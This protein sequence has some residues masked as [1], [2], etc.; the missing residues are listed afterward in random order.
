M[1]KRFTK[2]RGK[3]RHL[4]K[5]YKKRQKGGLVSSNEVL[6]KI[7]SIGYEFETD[8]LVPLSKKQ[9]T[10][11]TVYSEFDKKS[12]YD[13]LIQKYPLIDKTFF[14][15]L[16]LNTEIKKN[17]ITEENVYSL[18]V[19][20]DVTQNPFY[21]QYEN[22]LAIN[23]KL[24][25]N[26]L[27]D[28]DGILN[29]LPIYNAGD[30]EFASTY[31]NLTKFSDRNNIINVT[32]Q[33]SI[34]NIYNFLTNP[35]SVET[36]QITDANTIKRSTQ[37]SNELK[38]PKKM[39]NYD[40]L[41]LSLLQIF[42]TNI[43][44]QNIEYVRITPQMTFKS[45]LK[46]SLQIVN[47]LL[48]NNFMETNE[49]N[50]PINIEL[51]NL[52]IRFMKEST[53]YG[54]KLADKLSTLFAKYTKIHC[55]EPIIID[56]DK[57]AIV[58]TYLYYINFCVLAFEEKFTPLNRQ[59]NIS[60]ETYETIKYYKDLMLVK[61]RFNPYNLFRLNFTTEDKDENED[62]FVIEFVRFVYLICSKKFDSIQSL[63]TSNKT[64]VDEIQ[65][66]LNIHFNDDATD[67][68]PIAKI[69]IN[70]TFY[71]HPDKYLVSKSFPTEIDQIMI[72]YRGFSMALNKLLQEKLPKA[73]VHNQTLNGDY[74]LDILYRYATQN[75]S[76]SI[77]PTRF[78]KKRKFSE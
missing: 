9:Y 14:F 25:V 34:I 71:K 22:P 57:L 59:F 46:D 53:A 26:E 55:N 50:K 77:K 4:K 75:Q 47:Y 69:L 67:I 27:T 45:N 48:Q 66:L 74:T 18:Q 8:Y 24:L 35:T 29:I 70:K 10:E 37:V 65:T 72:E 21:K 28:N 19:Y 38:Q 17:I 32:F 52:S 20:N 13:F 64:D 44:K 33:D 42:P 2:K 1:N 39:Y 78:T 49:P 5:K 30:I 54:N 16:I 3:T 63:I 36:V 6:S 12:T 40:N 15:E 7:N 43:T 56:R 61:L 58:L 60:N 41:N 51:T 62:C 31:Y 11:N 73:E 68:S 76:M 23:N